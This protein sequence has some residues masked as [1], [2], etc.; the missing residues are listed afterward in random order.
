MCNQ[1][2]EVSVSSGIPYTPV[3]TY[4]AGCTCTWGNW[5]GELEKQRPKACPD[6]WGRDRGCRTVCGTVRA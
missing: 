2:L 1:G 4:S 3:G 6:L 5:G